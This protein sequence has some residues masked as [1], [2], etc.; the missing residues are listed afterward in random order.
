MNATRNLRWLGA[1]LIVGA[2]Y[3]VAGLVSAALAKSAASDQARVA[4][5]LAAWAISAVAFGAHIGYEH[6]RLR[7][8]SRTTALHVSLAV[9]LGAFGL[10]VAATL[11]AREMHKHFPVFALLLWPVLIALPAFVVALATA[12]VLTRARR[13]A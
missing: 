2:L 8:P 12:A 7:S 11:H 1:V 9:A 5:R 6:V 13:S 10:A 3:L 4:W